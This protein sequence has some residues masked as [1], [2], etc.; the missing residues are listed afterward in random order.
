MSV[1]YGSVS[2]QN[3]GVNKGSRVVES[4]IESVRPKLGQWGEKERERE[5]ERALEAAAKVLA[6]STVPSE[7]SEWGSL[8]VSFSSYPSLS[9]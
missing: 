5:R 7:L 2:S 9:H 6:F 4:F 3:R 8:C 1:K